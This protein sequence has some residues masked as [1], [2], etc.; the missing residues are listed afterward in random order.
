MT[1]AEILAQAEAELAQRNLAR[2]EA[3]LTLAKRRL[4]AIRAALQKL[5]RLEY[6]DPGDAQNVLD[7]DD[8]LRRGR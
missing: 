1:P 2:T 5:A 3:E 8:K 6:I 4:K 7:A